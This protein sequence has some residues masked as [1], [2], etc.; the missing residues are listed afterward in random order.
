MPIV[1]FGLRIADYG[2]VLLY[3]ESEI[4]DL[5]LQ[6]FQSAIRNP[7]SAILYPALARWRK[8]ARRI[9][10]PLFWTITNH[11]LMLAAV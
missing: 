1:D 9:I 11:A 7:Q 10:M 4:S 6:I 3:L 5:R 2:F 8:D